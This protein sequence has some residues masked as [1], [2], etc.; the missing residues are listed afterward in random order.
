MG[1]KAIAIKSVPKNGDRIE[2]FSTSLHK[3]GS[4]KVRLEVDRFQFLQRMSSVLC[5][6][7]VVPG[8]ER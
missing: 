8:K 4:V 1:S 6:D 2:D 5:L 3:L 7:A